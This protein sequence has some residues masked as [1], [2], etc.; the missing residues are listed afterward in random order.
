MQNSTITIKGT[1]CASCKA[2]LEEVVKDL[3]GV[4]SCTVDF[5]TGKTQIAHDESLD[6]DRLKREIA[7]VGAYSV[8]AI[9]P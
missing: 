5:V 2:L 7:T 4:Q 8:E 1:H 9:T 3:P 6:W